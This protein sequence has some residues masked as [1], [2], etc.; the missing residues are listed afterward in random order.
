[1][2]P[3]SVRSYDTVLS[4]LTN[5]SYI[6]YWITTSVYHILNSRFD[7][8]RV[9]LYILNQTSIIG[10]IAEILDGLSLGMYAG[11]FQSYLMQS[12]GLQVFINKNGAIT[13]TF[14]SVKWSNLFYDLQLMEELAEMILD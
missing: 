11:S 14:A 3:G 12:A 9:G 10:T 1:M 6:L 7:T 5:A 2:D 13:N 4:L 8:S